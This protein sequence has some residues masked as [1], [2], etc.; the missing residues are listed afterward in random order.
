VSRRRAWREG[1]QVHLRSRGRSSFLS[2]LLLD[3][4]LLDGDDGLA[5]FA[6][7]VGCRPPILPPAV[8]LP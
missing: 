5:V 1:A 8:L 6:S 2:S 4:K 3:A 7:H